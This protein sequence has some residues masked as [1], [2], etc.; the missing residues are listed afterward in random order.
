RDTGLAVEA[1]HLDEGVRPDVDDAFRFRALVGDVCL[2]E[3]RG[4]GDPIR[5][6]FGWKPLD[7]AHARQIDDTNLVFSPV[8]GIDLPAFGD[9]GNAF[10]TRHVTDGLDHRVRPQIHYVQEAG[11]E[12]GR[13]QVVVVLIDRQI[14]EALARRA[15]E[16]ELGDLAQR[17]AGCFTAGD[18]G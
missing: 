3:G 13:E 4:I 7:D 16:L 2:V 8:R 10:D 1:Q 18:A 9:V 5:L 15:R 6:L 14:V 12:M 11:A 17:R